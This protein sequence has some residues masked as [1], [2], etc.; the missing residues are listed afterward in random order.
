LHACWGAVQAPPGHLNLGAGQQAETAPPALPPPPS[1]PPGT[2]RSSSRAAWPTSSP[3]ATAAATGWWRR[4]S[5]GPGRCAQ[6][7]AA[8]GRCGGAAISWLPACCLRGAA[9][10][11]PHPATVAGVWALSCCAQPWRW[12]PSLTPAAPPACCPCAGG[13]AAQLR[14]AGDGAAGRPEAAGRAHQQ[15]GGAR[16]AAAGRPAS[17]CPPPA[18]LVCTPGRLVP[19]AATP[20]PGCCTAHATLRGPRLPPGPSRSPSPT[21]PLPTTTTTTTT[22]HACRAGPGDPGGARLGGRLPAVHDGQPH[23][24]R[25]PAP[26]RNRQ[27]PGDWAGP[28]AER[29]AGVQEAGRWAAAPWRARG[30]AAATGRAAACVRPPLPGPTPAA[31]PPP[32]CRR[33]AG[34][35]CP[36]CAALQSSR[37]PR[38]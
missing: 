28:P 30:Q 12:W 26:L 34:C 6:G 5:P 18:C 3:P 31:P 11:G 23:H 33:R 37:T 17:A 36:S 4:P 25:D 27:L 21:P 19:L 15:R 14:G 8:V 29:W 1:P 38:A 13:Q 16:A 22:T 2:R 20:G 10:P 9:V 35:R 24:R 32:P 7:R